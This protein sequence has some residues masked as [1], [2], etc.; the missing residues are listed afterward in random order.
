MENEEKKEILP[1]KIDN[2][3]PFIP[4]KKDTIKKLEAPKLDP[5]KPIEDPLKTSI[6]ETAKNFINNYENYTALD[7]SNLIE[8]VDAFAKK[9]LDENHYFKSYK[10]THAKFHLNQSIFLRSLPENGRNIEEECSLH[11]LDFIDDIETV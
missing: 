10:V 8:N 6:L 11:I 5:L 9:L 2:V 7:Y 1:E 4:R 3:V